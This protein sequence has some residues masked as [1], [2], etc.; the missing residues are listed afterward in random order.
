MAKRRG[1]GPPEVRS[2]ATSR[3][4]CWPQDETRSFKMCIT[5]I[6]SITIRQAGPKVRVRVGGTRMI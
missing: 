3:D 1:R 2:P 6:T 4:V 5:S